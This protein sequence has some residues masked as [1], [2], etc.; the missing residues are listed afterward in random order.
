M[1]NRSQKHE[2]DIKLG[3]EVEP[4]IRSRGPVVAVRLSPELFGR[5]N[6]YASA[7]GLT[8]SD[9]FRQGVE[10][11]ISGMS[12]IVASGGFIP[13]TMYRVDQLPQGSARG[14][15]LPRTDLEKPAGTSGVLTFS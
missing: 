4:V 1:S 12:T 6:E 10:R 14:V 15:E 2:T 3:E 9:V 5:V 7:R 13:A 11:L 8:L